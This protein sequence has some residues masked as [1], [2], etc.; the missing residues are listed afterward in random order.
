M[1][2]FFTVISMIEHVVPQFCS[3]LLSPPSLGT[4]GSILMDSYEMLEYISQDCK[5][6]I[7]TRVLRCDIFIRSLLILM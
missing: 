2:R 7:L 3:W 5:T 1:T 4:V 6:D